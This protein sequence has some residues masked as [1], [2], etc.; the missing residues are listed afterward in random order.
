MSKCDHPARPQIEITIQP[1]IAQRFS[2]LFDG[3]YGCL[4]L[5]A[6]DRPLRDVAI[7]LIDLGAPPQ[8]MITARHL[9]RCRQITTTL[10]DAAAGIDIGFAIESDVVVPFR[11]PARPTTGSGD[12]A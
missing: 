8:T 6:S 2:G 4:Q 1:D 7:E 5:C 12:A 9:S 3:F 10:H 11:R